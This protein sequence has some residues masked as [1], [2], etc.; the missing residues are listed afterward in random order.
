MVFIL[1]LV[2]QVWE[3][4]TGDNDQE[5]RG[6]TQEKQADSSRIL[7]FRREEETEEMGDEA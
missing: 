5:H 1:G 7:T 4:L 6:T 3:E 2:I